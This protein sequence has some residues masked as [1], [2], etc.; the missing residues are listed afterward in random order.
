MGRKRKNLNLH[1]VKG[2]YST[3]RVGGK[4]RYKYFGTHDPEVAYQAYQ[5]WRTGVDQA[6]RAGM[7]FDEW[8]ADIKR[9]KMVWRKLGARFILSL[10]DS[11]D[12]TE[13]DFENQFE[14]WL[15]DRGRA[16]SRKGIQ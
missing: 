13:G 5:K 7:S 16:A 12:G 2:Y 8:M 11:Y 3:Y 4:T 14:R 1:K 9:R 6:K 15:K 10:P